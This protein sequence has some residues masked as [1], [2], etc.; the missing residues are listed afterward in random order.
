MSDMSFHG[1]HG[2]TAAPVR[3]APRKRLARG[4]GLLAGAGVSVGL[5]AAIAWG[6]AQ[7]LA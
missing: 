3:V 5:W 2:L 7:L 6:V 4:Y 1:R